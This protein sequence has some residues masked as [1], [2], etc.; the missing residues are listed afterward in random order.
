MLAALG[1]VSV[2]WAL[3][4]VILVLILLAVAQRL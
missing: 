1:A 3:L 2:L 4:V